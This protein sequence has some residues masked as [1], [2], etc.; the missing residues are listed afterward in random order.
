MKS[1]DVL[2]M[3]IG[4]GCFAVD[5]LRVKEVIRPLAIAPL[6][7]APELVEGIIELRGAVMPVV[8]L[9]R[10]FAVHRNAA[11]APRAARFVI[12]GVAGRVIA[13]VVDGVLGVFH[14]DA[15]DIR[16]PDAVGPLPAREL[17]FGVTTIDGKI[18]L[19]IDPDALLS[20]DETRAIARLEDPA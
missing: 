3:V 14:L 10:R 16:A 20:A 11:G 12:L 1:R 17:L 19:V 6:P 18:C 9:R 5:I 7:S 2:A 13:C 4:D 15:A 8:D